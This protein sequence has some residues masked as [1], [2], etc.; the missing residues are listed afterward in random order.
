MNNFEITTASKKPLLD[1]Q[2]E[3][4]KYNNPNLYM[5]STAFVAKLRAYFQRFGVNDIVLE[6]DM[7]SMHEICI[8]MKLFNLPVF[9]RINQ[10]SLILVMTSIEMCD[11]QA[12]TSW[13]NYQGCLVQ[14][15][16]LED[17]KLSEVFLDTLTLMEGFSQSLMREVAKARKQILDVQK[18]HLEQ[19]DSDLVW[20]APLI[21]TIITIL[22]MDDKSIS[23]ISDIDFII[24]LLL[25]TGLVSSFCI[26]MDFL[27]KDR[28]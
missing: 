20:K 5:V 19:K 21:A 23:A 10:N 11:Y 25:N 8:S 15:T 26:G 1:T 3:G 7:T 14:K 16:Y 2:L 6:K 4:F 22:T 18:Q 27:F 17:P 24:T 28:K 13:L 12:D 9:F